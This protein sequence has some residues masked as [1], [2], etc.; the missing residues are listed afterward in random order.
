[1]LQE[2]D[3]LKAIRR[4][5]RVF[6]KLTL[7]SILI[8]LL[9]AFN[10]T[11]FAAPIYAGSFEHNIMLTADNIGH[12]IA[13]Q[14][15]HQPNPQE[16]SGIGQL[17]PVLADT[18]CFYGIVSSFVIFLLFANIASECKYANYESSPVLMRVRLDR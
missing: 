4:H 6:A 9:L 8:V 1:M 10:Y 15:L 14:E 3:A 17:Q 2:G 5:R 18:V 11:V 16:L 12:C 7:F 13:S